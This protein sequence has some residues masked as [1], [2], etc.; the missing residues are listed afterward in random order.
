MPL[1]LKEEGTKMV[2]WPFRTVL[3]TPNYLSF[4]TVT[5]DVNTHSCEY[6]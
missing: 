3:L 1:W 6:I 2:L 5:I 4:S